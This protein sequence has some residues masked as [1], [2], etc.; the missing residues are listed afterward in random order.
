M[1]TTESNVVRYGFTPSV[2]IYTFPFPFLSRSDIKVI[3]TDSEGNDTTLILGT[4]YTVSYPGDSGAV[5]L[6]G[7]LSGKGWE[8]LT[9]L[10]EISLTQTT[11]LDNGQSMDAV[12]VESSLD[13]LLMQIQQVAEQVERSMKVSVSDGSVPPEVHIPDED[14]RKNTFLGFD[15]NG[16]MTTIPQGDFDGLVAQAQAAASQ[17]MAAANQAAE[18]N[19]AMQQTVEEMSEEMAETV[20]YIN[21]NA[22]R[23]FRTVI[24]DGSTKAFTVEH[25]LGT[26]QI[27]VYLWYTGDGTLPFY[28]V[29]KNPL[30]PDQITIDFETAPPIDSVEVLIST[31][32]AVER[33]EDVTPDDMADSTEMS[34][35]DVLAIL[36]A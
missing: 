11:D 24:G 2:S 35:A 13:R 18:V 12:T 4:D 10:R 16:E 33:T 3:A 26:A 28:S 21:A 9:I 34:G 31:I 5:T 32:R 27:M 6:V 23:G 15:G 20:D 36:N 22:G 7:D 8:K 19:Q 1:V 14:K 17:S 25:G 30:T 29:E